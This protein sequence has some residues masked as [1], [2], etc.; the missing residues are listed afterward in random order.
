MSPHSLSKIGY[1]PWTYEHPWGG[2]SSSEFPGVPSQPRAA[3][4]RWVWELQAETGRHGKNAKKEL[5]FPKGAL[6]E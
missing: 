5:L 1:D 4:W 6:P 2:G 3:R